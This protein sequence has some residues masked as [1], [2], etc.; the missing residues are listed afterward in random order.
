MQWEPPAFEEIAM[1]AEFTSY[2]DDL[3]A[4]EAAPG[5]DDRAGTCESVS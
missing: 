3:A 1:N 2:C 5:R 4:E